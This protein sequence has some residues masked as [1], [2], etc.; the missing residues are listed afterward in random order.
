MGKTMILK[1]SLE[2][3]EMPKNCFIFK[4]N[5]I[6]YHCPFNIISVINNYFI[7]LLELKE[8]VNATVTQQYI[9]ERICFIY[10]FSCF[11]II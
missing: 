1:K 11:N 8:T 6:L 5:P 7:K 4:L 10:R 9:Y 2:Y 3:S